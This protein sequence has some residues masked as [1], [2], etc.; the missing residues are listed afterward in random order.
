MKP[1]RMVLPAEQEM[2]DAAISYEHQVSGLGKEFLGRIAK[3]IADI[4]AHEERWPVIR[5]DIRRPPR[6]P[7]SV[8]AALSR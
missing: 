5:A 7:L 3:A 8:R 2:L 6:V 4:A 1:V